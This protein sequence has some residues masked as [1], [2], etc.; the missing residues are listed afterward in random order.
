MVSLKVT[1]ENGRMNILYLSFPPQIAVF[2]GGISEKTA[3]E[4]Y[5]LQI[6]CLRKHDNFIGEE[7]V[8]QEDPCNKC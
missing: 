1:L 7:D 2:Q 5:V 6:W 8:L 4:R 3:L